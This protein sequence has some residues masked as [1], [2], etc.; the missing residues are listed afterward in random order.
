M[1]I[2]SVSKLF[3]IAAISLSI[4]FFIA[5]NS[6]N[7]SNNNSGD[8]TMASMD[9]DAIPDTA[10]KAMAT[11]SGTKTDTTVNGTAMFEKDGNE[12]K[13]HLELTVP[14]KANS[15]VAVHFHAMSDCGDMGKMAGGHWNPTNENHGKWGTGNFHSG[16]IGNINL[17]ASGKGTIDITSN[18]WT[19]GGD[20]TTNIIGKTIIVHS[21]VDDYK[22]QPAGNSG[23]RI[24]CGVIQ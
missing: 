20:T 22:S 23:E 11:I 6:N 8:T 24:A 17:D 7:S 1:K 2:K 21:G 10:S 15:S 3:T 12:V 5:C 16:D 14:K 19:L 9:N 18:R 13:M 4:T